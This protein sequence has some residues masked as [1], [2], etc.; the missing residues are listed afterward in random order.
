MNMRAAAALHA[1]LI[2]CILQNVPAAAQDFPGPKVAD[3]KPGDVRVI[4]TAAIREPVDA[5]V[6]QAQQ[7]IGRPVVVEYGS[8]RG[9]KDRDVEG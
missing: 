1:A 9:A 2:L 5:I 4:A 3:A 7:A 6:A 8:A